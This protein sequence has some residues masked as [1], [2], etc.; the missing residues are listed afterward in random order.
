MRRNTRLN[1]EWTQFTKLDATGV[2]NVIYME[3][4]V[5]MSNA[6]TNACPKNSGIQ[7]HLDYCPEPITMQNAYSSGHKVKLGQ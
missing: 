6:Y 1:Q 4:S 2:C 5:T 7:C 3:K